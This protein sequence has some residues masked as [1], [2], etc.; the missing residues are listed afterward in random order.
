MPTRTNKYFHYSTA[1]PIK[2]QA[3][4][5]MY[6]DGGGNWVPKVL[7]DPYGIADGMTFT[8]GGNPTIFEW[9]ISWIDDCIVGQAFINEQVFTE[10]GGDQVKRIVLD[11]QT[12]QNESEEHGCSTGT[13]I[14][15]PSTAE[16]YLYAYASNESEVVNI[17]P[18]IGDILTITL[19]SNISG[20]YP[21]V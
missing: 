16:V 7:H 13:Y 14:D 12:L 2:M 15:D 8:D 17:T 20:L 6:T 5:G 19:Y 11:Y 9:E 21:L 4:F 18:Q 3:Q 10:G 1:L